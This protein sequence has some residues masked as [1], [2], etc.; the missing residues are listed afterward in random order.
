MAIRTVIVDDEPFARQ[1]IRDFLRAEKDVEVVGE[2]ADGTEAVRVIRAERPDLVFLDVQIPEPDGFGVVAALGPEAV[3]RIVFAT[4]HDRYALRAF[5]AH[6][7]DYLLKPFDR[8][9]FRDALGRARRAI[10]ADAAGA[11][12]ASRLRDLIEDA[13]SR[14]SFLR[15]FAV[16]CKRGVRLLKPEDILW[17]EADGSYTVLHTAAAEHL[18][19]ETLSELERKL[20]PAVFVRTHRSSIV[21]VEHIREVQPYFHGES[22]LVLDNDRRLGVSRSYRGNIRK[23]L[24]G[25]V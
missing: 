24:D 20:D 18:L 16:P 23:I 6:A 5:D 15:R 14:P 4:A 13:R 7:L 22:V 10:A 2:A 8:D 25:R 11:D 1:K 19:H 12:F 9:R 3:P 21:N 17:I